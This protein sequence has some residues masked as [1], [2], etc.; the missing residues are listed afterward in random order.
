MEKTKFKH[1]SRKYKSSSTVYLRK[2]S[3]ETKREIDSLGMAVKIVKAMTQRL[4]LSFYKMKKLKL[5]I[6]IYSTQELITQRSFSQSRG[7]SKREREIQRGSGMW[8]HSDTMQKSSL[9]DGLHHQK[10]NGGMA[11]EEDQVG[12]KVSI[13]GREGC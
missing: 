5:L 8:F 6:G 1:V 12:L 3:C 10:R 9:K 7:R 11:S 4:K 13:A 2:I